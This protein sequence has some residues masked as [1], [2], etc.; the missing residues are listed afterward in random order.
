[1]TTLVTGTAG[2]IGYHTAERLLARGEPV[3][4]VDVV[5]AYYDPSLKEARLQR[6]AAKA[7][8]SEARI[9]IADAAALTAIFAAHRPKRVIHL[10]AQ[11]GVR[12]S[13]ENPGAYIDSNLVGFANILEGCRHHGVEHLTYASTS[14]VYG[15]NQDMPFSERHGV[16]HPLSLYAATKRANE[17]MAHTYAHLYALPCTGLR[18]F[19]VYGPWGRPDMALFKFTKAILQG[20]PIE[21]YNHGQMQRDFTYI[22]DIVEGVIRA[23]D[24]AAEVEAA[25]DASVP[26]PDPSRSGV[27][28]Y[29]IFNIGRGAPVQLM[30]Y[31]ETLEA[32]LGKQ[33]TYHMLPMQQGDV[34][35]TFADTSALDA[36]VGY[37]PST[38]IEVGVG[39]FVD[40]YRAYYAV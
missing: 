6:L 36:A 20:Q 11:A 4:G 15:A 25:W 1:M 8:F 30:A 23:S 16:G 18:F 39:R 14:S 40:W 17:L 13:V 29:R 5:N 22:D 7:G 21:V 37:R 34:S 24:Q 10:A 31:I 2:F 12:Y 3:V 32:K 28:P 35:A 38:P 9:D 33:A 26:H 19:T 27:A